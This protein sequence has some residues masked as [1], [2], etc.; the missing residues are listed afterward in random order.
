MNLK[1][2]L[3]HKIHECKLYLQDPP[4]TGRNYKDRLLC[5]FANENGSCMVYCI[6]L[7]CAHCIYSHDCETG[8]IELK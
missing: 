5:R 8:E 7:G 6:E 3:S 2:A 4:L 1:N